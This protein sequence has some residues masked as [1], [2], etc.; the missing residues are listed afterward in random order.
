MNTFGYSFETASAGK[1]KGSF[2]N[3]LGGFKK[4]AV[5]AKAKASVPSDTK[6]ATPSAA[7]ASNEAADFKKD[8]NCE[9]TLQHEHNR[10]AESTDTTDASSRK[11]PKKDT[12]EA[13]KGRSNT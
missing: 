13:T 1:S 8:S 10:A 11:R 5:T 6:A 3:L 7:T 9:Q 2:K 12:E 4:K